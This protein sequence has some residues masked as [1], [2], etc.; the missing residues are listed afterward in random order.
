[1]PK[2]S[3]YDLKF[4]A[5]RNGTKRIVRVCALLR[6]FPHDS[7]LLKKFSSLSKNEFSS[8]YS[9]ATKI[10]LIWRAFEFSVQLLHVHIYCNAEVHL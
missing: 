4:S 6:M 7:S 5:V 9:K 8:D 10:S 1:M 2:N 3:K